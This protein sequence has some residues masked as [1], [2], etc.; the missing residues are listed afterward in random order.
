MFYHGNILKRVSHGEKKNGKEE[1]TPESYLHKVS[2][3]TGLTGDFFQLRLEPNTSCTLDSSAP[4]VHPPTL[5]LLLIE[6]VQNIKFLWFSRG[7]KQQYP[8]RCY[9]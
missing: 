5:L 7:A 4:L 2:L 8:H 9:N 3:G 6:Y 1:N